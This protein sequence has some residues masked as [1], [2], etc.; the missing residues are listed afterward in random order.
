[1]P[2]DCL[3]CQIVQGAVPAEKVYEDEHTLAFL[4]IKPVNP[5]HTL[6]I[7]KQHY[8]N[9]LT[10]PE[11]EAE[12]L[13]VS[14]KRV[15]E[16]IQA[17]TTA[18]AFN[19]GMNNGAAAGQIIFHAHVHIMPRTKKDNYEPWHGKEYQAEEMKL[20]AEAIRAQLNN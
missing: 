17:A 7:P 3:F 2:T 12:H 18:A 13:F 10:M 11:T 1:M 8:E 16:A 15:A 5:G 19:I 20:V 6:V 4:D 14:V 9:L